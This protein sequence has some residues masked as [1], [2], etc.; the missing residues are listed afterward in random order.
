MSKVHGKTAVSGNLRKTS[1]GGNFES[2]LTQKNKFK[3]GR[4]EVLRRKAENSKTHRL[5]EISGL[6][7]QAK[8]SGRRQH[9]LV[10]R[11]SVGVNIKR[12]SV[13]GSLGKKSAKSSEMAN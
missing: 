4:Q 2:T 5:A 1:V 8:K 7:R 12:S 9:E 3:G 11:K 10:V 6:C 13:G